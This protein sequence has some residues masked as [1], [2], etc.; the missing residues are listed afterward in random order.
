MR[1]GDLPL[2]AYVLESGANDRVFDFLL[3]VGP[4]VIVLVAIVGR[5]LATVGISVAYL[6]FFVAYVLYK[7][8]R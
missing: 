6:V 1:L 2:V 7:G 4:A 3:L 5:T 8:L